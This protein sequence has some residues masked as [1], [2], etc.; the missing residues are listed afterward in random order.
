MG[1]IAHLLLV[2]TNQSEGMRTSK[3]Y[4]KGIQTRNHT[5][6][7]TKTTQRGLGSISKLEMWYPRGKENIL[8]ELITR[9]NHFRFWKYDVIA[10]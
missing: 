8:K 5:E 10:D 1:Q 9:D 2:N 6:H 7:S 3:T 4:Q